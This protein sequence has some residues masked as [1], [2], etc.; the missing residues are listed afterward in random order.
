MSHD[1]NSNRSEIEP[2]EIR[3]NHNKTNQFR[4]NLIKIMSAFFGHYS[5]G[6]AMMTKTVQL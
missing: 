4:E 6:C 2:T 3:S 5:T 1:Q